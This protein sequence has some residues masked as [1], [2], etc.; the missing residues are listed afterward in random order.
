MKICW[1]NLERLI[2]DSLIKAFRSKKN[3]YDL[4]YEVDVC[5]SCGEPF[6]SRETS[7]EYC[8]SKCYGMTRSMGID[9]KR[10]WQRIY[11]YK[12]YHDHREKNIGRQTR[13]RRN[14]RSKILVSAAFDRAKQKNLPYD[15]DTEWC[16]NEL[17]KGCAMTNIPFGVDQN[18]P[19]APSIDRVDSSK[20]YTKDNCRIVLK[21]M[22]FWKREYSDDALYQIA[23]AFV[24]KYEN[25]RSST[26]N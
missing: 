5:L 1:D 9:H 7:Q 4:F 22:N 10:E 13:Y 17:T 16:R 20:G 19:T 26:H 12:Y 3:R 23:K 24:E 21:V 15:L 2:Y 25:D 18:V 6:L 11:Q 8:C 14:N